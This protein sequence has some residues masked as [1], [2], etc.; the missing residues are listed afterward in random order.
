MQKFA[1]PHASLAFVLPSAKASLYIRAYAYV[2]IREETFLFF[3]AL[4]LAG[5]VSPHECFTFPGLQ[6]LRC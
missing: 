6:A 5:N 2:Y 3:W 1:L 4:T